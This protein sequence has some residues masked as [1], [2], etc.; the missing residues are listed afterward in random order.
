MSLLI[1]ARHGMKSLVSM[2]LTMYRSMLLLSVILLLIGCAGQAT[3]PS[4]ARAALTGDE[5][6]FRTLAYRLLS[7]RPGRTDSG[8]LAS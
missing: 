8:D 2:E 4:P 7:R 6:A 3:G 5:V 1:G